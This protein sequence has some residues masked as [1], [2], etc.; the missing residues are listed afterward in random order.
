[1]I[2]LVLALSTLMQVNPFQNGK[3]HTVKLDTS[4]PKS[5]VHEVKIDNA[6]DSSD[7]SATGV[8]KSKKLEKKKKADRK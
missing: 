7:R 3:W 2:I 6:A 8:S 5:V 1:M 4:K